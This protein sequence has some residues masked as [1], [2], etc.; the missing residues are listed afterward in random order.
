MFDFPLG[1]FYRAATTV[2][3]PSVGSVGF[4]APAVV[5]CLLDT[6]LVGR[7][8]RP[9]PGPPARRP[10]Q[11]RAVSGLSAEEAL[12]L[13]RQLLAARQGLL[14]TRLDLADRLHDVGTLR[15][16]LLDSL[17]VHVCLVVERREVD[18]QTTELAQPRE[19]GAD[20][21]GEGPAAT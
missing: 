5:G 9:C 4:G 15:D 12:D 17:H 11:F 21:G 19:Q 2:L 3:R 14:G 20:R 10:H 16:P 13:R 8:G 18:P 6:V 1:T 7:P